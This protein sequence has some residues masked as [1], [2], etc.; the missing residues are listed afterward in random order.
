VFFGSVGFNALF[1]LVSSAISLILLTKFSII[2]GF[3]SSR[4]LVALNR[5]FM[6]VSHKPIEIIEIFIFS[7]FSEIHSRLNPFSAIEIFPVSSLFFV[8]AIFIFLIA[9]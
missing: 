2:E 5:F 3:L 9:E 6:E 4:V 8:P 7:A 1:Y